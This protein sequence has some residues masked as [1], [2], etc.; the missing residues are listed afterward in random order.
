MKKILLSVSIIA[1][2]AAVVFGITTAFFSDT[3]TSTGNTFTAG[4]LDLIVDINGNDQNPLAGPIFSEPDM[5]PGDKGEVTLSLKVDDNPACGFVNIDMKSDLDNSCNEP[6]QVAEPD[7]KLDN[8]G[9]LNDEV[10]FMIW[11]DNDCDNVYDEG[12]TLLTEGPLT[13]DKTYQIGELPIAPA[14]QCYGV[15][16]C[17]GTWGAG[18]TCDGSKL[19]NQ[20]Q[21]DSFDGDLI[22]T[23]QQK[24]N[25]YPSGC[26]VD[27][28][29]PTPFPPAI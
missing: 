25:Q 26:P 22:F 7:C 10:R 2:V 29:P 28:V 1:A 14:K 19:G 24:R 20:S 4:S 27:F 16:Y 9:E 17:F 13:E 12:E 23:A 18:M 15:A 21:S 5:K 3:E 6:E 11:G 8:V